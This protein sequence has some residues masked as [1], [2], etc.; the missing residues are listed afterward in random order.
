VG[1]TVKLTSETLVHVAIT[2]QK[3]KGTSK[4]EI[5]KDF[6]DRADDIL[7]TLQHRLIL[8]SASSLVLFFLLR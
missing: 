7:L 2:V 3:Q 4:A 5:L 1:S 6:E 8:C